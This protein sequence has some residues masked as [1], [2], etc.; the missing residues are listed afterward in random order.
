V[1][2]ASVSPRAHRRWLPGRHRGRA[3]RV[4]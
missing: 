1:P 4:R 2:N 3:T